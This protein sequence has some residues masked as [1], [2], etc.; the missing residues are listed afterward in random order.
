MFRHA[1][2]RIFDWLCMLLAW[3]L[4]IHGSFL[5]LSAEAADEWFRFEIP[6]RNQPPAASSCGA[7]ISACHNN[8]TS[9]SWQCYCVK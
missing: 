9:T 2:T 1:L 7:K 5:V 6:Y 8:A 4:L 3:W